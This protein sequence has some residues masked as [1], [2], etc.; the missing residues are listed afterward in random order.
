MLG[1]VSELTGDCSHLK[2]AADALAVENPIFKV[3]PLSEASHQT[4]VRAKK[5]EEML[6]QPYKVMDD[7]SC[8]VC[9]RRFLS[10]YSKTTLFNTVVDHFSFDGRISQLEHLLSSHQFHSGLSIGDRS[11]FNIHC[12]SFIHTGTTSDIG[13]RCSPNGRRCFGPSIQHSSGT[14]RKGERTIEE[15]QRREESESGR[16]C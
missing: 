3:R 9:K 14:T 13:D 15:G 5:F 12:P 7:L 4:K 16:R 8:C 11:P 2:A 6:S 1:W 10:F